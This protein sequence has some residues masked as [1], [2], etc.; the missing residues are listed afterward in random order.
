MFNLSSLRS[1]LLNAARCFFAHLARSL[2]S[3]VRHPTCASPLS[4][5]YSCSSSCRLDHSASLSVTKPCCHASIRC[6]NDSCWS[7][8][9]TSC[10]SS[11]GCASQTLATSIASQPSATFIWSSMAR[12]LETLVVSKRG[13]LSTIHTTST[14]PYSLPLP[15]SSASASSCRL[16]STTC[17]EP[18]RESTCQDSMLAP[19][20][21]PLRPTSTIFPLSCSSTTPLAR[22]KPSS[23]LL[24]PLFRS[25][26]TTC[27]AGRSGPPAAALLNRKAKKGREVPIAMLPHR[28][29]LGG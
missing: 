2:S 26:A 22:Q 5:M 4:F 19:D 6:A 27:N 21:S 14:S 13:S 20:S 15:S 18:P 3:P 10:S 24:L 29:G 17:L 11:E 8:S 1:P 7:M 28:N 25:E 16:T 9:V 23:S 12:I